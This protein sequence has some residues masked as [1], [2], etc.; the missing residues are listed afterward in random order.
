MFWGYVQAFRAQNIGSAKSRLRV[1]AEDIRDQL[2]K[3]GNS[4]ELCSQLGAVLGMLG[5]C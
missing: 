4:S 2:Q 3:V 5:D 1:C